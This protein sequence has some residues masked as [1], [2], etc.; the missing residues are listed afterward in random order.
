MLSCTAPFVQPIVFFYALVLSC[1]ESN[2]D[3]INL[4]VTTSNGGS[5]GSCIDEERS[6]LR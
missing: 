4:N 6:Q 5:L 2:L 3:S 1:I